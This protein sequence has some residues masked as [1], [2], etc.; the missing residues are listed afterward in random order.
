[1]TTVVHFWGRAAPYGSGT[2]QLVH[3]VITGPGSE[4]ARHRTDDPKALVFRSMP[5]RKEPKSRG[6]VLLTVPARKS[7][8][9]DPVDYGVYDAENWS[10]AKLRFELPDDVS[11]VFDQYKSNH[12]VKLN[13][14]YTTDE[15]AVRRGTARCTKLG[16]TCIL[17]MRQY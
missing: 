12:Q 4:F 9:G 16:K 5:R 11:R 17:T 3:Q 15:G 14:Q 2:D 13:W 1:M 6:R 7:G 10:G 8:F